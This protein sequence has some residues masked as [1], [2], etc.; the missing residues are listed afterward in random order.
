MRYDCPEM[1]KIHEVSIRKLIYSVLEN[2]TI[3]PRKI[4]FDQRLK[5]FLMVGDAHRMNLASLTLP[6][7]Y[8]SKILVCH[9]HWHHN[10]Y[11]MP[12][13]TKYTLTLELAHAT[14]I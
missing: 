4:R 6:Y 13:V 3:T 12:M 8:E 2:V 1:K 7:L 14:I 5:N 11:Y 9:Y 10:N